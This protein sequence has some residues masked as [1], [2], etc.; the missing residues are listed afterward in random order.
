MEPGTRFE[1]M[2]V[3]HRSLGRTGLRWVAGSLC[4]LSGGISAG[5]WMIGA[6]PVIG[7][8]GLEVLLAV[9]LINRHARAGAS[10]R[11][12]LSDAGL[13]V[14]RT[15][16]AGRGWERRLQGGWLRVSLQE[17]PGRT[18]ALLLHDRR[19]RLEVGADLGE[20]EKRALALA[21]REALH[22]QRHPSFDNAQLREGG[23]AR[24]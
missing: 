7:F 12:L 8:T 14:V 2:I 17:R 11:L 21:L 10:E 16:G 23:P 3:P 9:W 13:R 18:P 19:A 20:A 4:V 22:R 24:G 6:W 1:A 15:D 5:L